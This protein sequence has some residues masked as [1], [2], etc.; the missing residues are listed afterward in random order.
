MVVNMISTSLFI[1]FSI[2]NHQVQSIGRDELL[3][4][5][6]LGTDPAH[7]NND[8]EKCSKQTKI[9]EIRINGNDGKLYMF[10][11]DFIEEGSLDQDEND[12]LKNED[13][14]F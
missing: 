8:V 11:N 6:D 7:P 12:L 2:Y 1:L 13:V 9:V 4:D 10:R 3:I 5:R 14:T